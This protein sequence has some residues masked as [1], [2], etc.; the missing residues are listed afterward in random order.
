MGF[1]AGFKMFFFKIILF[2]FLCFSNAYLSANPGF[3]EIL[4]QKVASFQ[5]NK[6]DYLVFY[7]KAYYP[8]NKGIPEMIYYLLVNS[9][10]R[11]KELVALTEKLA[12]Q[13]IASKKTGPE[14]Y[15]LHFFLIENKEEALSILEFT[16]VCYGEIASAKEALPHSFC[17][18]PFFHS[19]FTITD[20]KI[21]AKIFYGAH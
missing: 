18:G 6:D 17:A 21:T 20:R 7:A 9:Q 15:T 13:V 16:N 19:F 1:S 3:P 4:R 14:S 2:L 10:Y 11:K 5:P 8:P 12:E